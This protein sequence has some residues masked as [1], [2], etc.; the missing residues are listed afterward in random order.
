VPGGVQFG[1]G[2]VLEGEQGVVG[3]RKGLQDL[4]EF[5]LRW[6]LLALL[7]VLDDARRRASPPCPRQKG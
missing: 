1:I 6:A 3:A 7:G 4:V 5:S 2:G